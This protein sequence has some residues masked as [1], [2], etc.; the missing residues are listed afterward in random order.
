MLT[1][2]EVLSAHQIDVP[3]HLVAQAEVPVLGVPQTQGDLFFLPARPSAKT[4]DPVPAGGIQLVRGEA[5]ANTHW[6]DAYDGPV[7]WAPATAGGADLGVMTVP[8]GSVAM[9]THTDEHGANAFAPGVYVVRRQ[10]Q[11][12]DEIRLVAD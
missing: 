11:Q 8:D 10:R 2:E 9:V 4:G 1:Y 7:L 12:A 3:P 6:L 5:S